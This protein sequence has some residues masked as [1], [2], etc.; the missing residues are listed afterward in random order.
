MLPFTGYATVAYIPESRVVGL[1]KI[2]RLVDVYARRLQVQER[3]TDQIAD[4]MVEHLAVKGCGV[5][6]TSGHS[7]MGMRGIKKS[8]AKMTTSALR[9]VFLEP[10]IRNEFLGHH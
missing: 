8:G 7:C 9:G 3:M 2:A 10:A 5:A 4:A 1:S 6:I